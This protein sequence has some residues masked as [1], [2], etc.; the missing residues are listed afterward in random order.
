MAYLWN[1][2][3]LNKDLARIDGAI[4]AGRYNLAMKLAHRSLRQY[5]SSILKTNEIYAEQ[6][7][8]DNVRQ[9]AVYISKY[10]LKYF[11]KYNI[12][13][14]ERRV[15]FISLVSNFIFIATMN[16]TESD[17]HLTDKATATY[18]RE[19][20]YNIISYLMRYFG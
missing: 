4:M 12:P 17:E 20:V 11:R 2:E 19:N 5:Y 15:I 1:T 9:M 18:A 14:S 3:R 8:A 13:Y 7:K 6:I 16:L 10:L